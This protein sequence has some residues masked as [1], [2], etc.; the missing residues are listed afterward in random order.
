MLRDQD[1][2]IKPM[3]LYCPCIIVGSWDVL[4][5]LLIHFRIPIIF[6]NDE[7]MG[8]FHFHHLKLNLFDRTALK[9]SLRMLFASLFYI[10][11]ELIDSVIILT[12]ADSEYGFQLLIF[13]YITMRPV[14]L[15]FKSLFDVNSHCA[16]RLSAFDQNTKSLIFRLAFQAVA[17]IVLLVSN[18]FIFAET[19]TIHHYHIVITEF[20]M[21]FIHSAV[22]RCV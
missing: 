17:S 8:R 15:A 22:I 3:L 6:H 20:L 9:F 10:I 4:W 19:M 11:W 14:T 5:A 1:I 12:S 7:D 16:G 18:S 21:P 13:K 2:P